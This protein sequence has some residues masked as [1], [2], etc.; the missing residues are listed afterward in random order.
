[1]AATD[2]AGNQATVTGSIEVDTTTEVTAAL[3]AASDT[4][5]AN[6]DGITNIQT[7]TFSGTA[8]ADAAIVVSINNKTYTGTANADGQ[9]S[10]Q[11]TDSLNDGSY[12]YIVTA[13][14]LAGNTANSEGT[15]Q[16]DTSTDVTVRLN[17]SSDSGSS[18]SDTITRENTP[19]FSGVGEANSTVV[20]TINGKHYNTTAAGDG[21]W[22]L[23]VTD[24]LPDGDHTYEVTATDIAGNTNTATGSLTIETVTTLTGGLSASSDTGSSNSDD[25]T[26]D[27]TPAF[28]GTGEPGA[29]VV[30]SI[31]DTTYNSVIDGEGK[32]AIAVGDELADG[33]YVYQIVSTDV[34]GNQSNINGTLTIDTSTTVTASLASE[35]DTGSS[36]N[37]GITNV[38]TPTFNGLAEAGAAIVLEINNK[39]YNGTADA[40][41]QWSIDVGD[42]LSDCSYDYTVTATD[43]A[44]NTAQST[45]QIQVDS[46][47]SVTAL[48]DAASDT[49]SS[50]SDTITKQ[51][52]PFF[53]G[54][55]EAGAAISLTIDGKNYTT[56]TT[57]AGTWSVQ[58]TDALDDGAHNY[59][60]T[61]TDVAGNTDTATGN[62]TIDN[63]TYNTVVAADGSWSIEVDNSLNDGT[64]DY[65]AV[66]TDLAGNQTPMT[67]SIEID[68]QAPALSGVLSAA[69]D[70]GVSDS[71]TITNDSMPTFSGS[72]EANAEIRLTINDQHY[73][74]SVGS[75]GVWSLEL[76]DALNDG[77]YSYTVTATDIAGN[78]ATGNGAITIDT[79]A[80]PL[81]GGLDSAS[82]SGVVGDGLTSDPT[83]TFSGTGENGNEVTLTIGSANYTTTIVNGAWSITTNTLSPDD[84]DYTIVAE[85]TAGNT[86]E[87]SGSITV[88][89]TT[90]VTADLA[91]ASDSGY[92]DDDNI[93]NVSSP[94]IAGT[95]E[96]G[97]GISLE[98]AGNTYTTT[99]LE[100]GTWSLQ[101]PPLVDGSYNYT[102]TAT[103]IPG[104]TATVTNNIIIDT[105]DAPNA[106][107]LDEI[108]DSGVSN[109]D[110]VTNVTTPLFSGVTDANVF[111]RFTIDGLTYQ[112][113]SSST[114]DWQVQL[115]AS[116]ELAEGTY[117]YTIVTEDYAGNVSGEYTDTV[118]IDLSTN[119]TIRLDATS[120][121]GISN[122]DSITKEPTPVLSG[123]GETGS[124]RS[125][126]IV[127][128]PSTYTTTVSD[129]GIWSITATSLDDGSYTANVTI[130][131]LAGNSNTESTTFFI[132]TETLAPTASLDS[133][134]DSGSSDSDG[135][136][137]NILPRFSGT[138]EAGSALTFTINGQSYNTTVGDDG[139]WSIQL[140]TALP[141]GTHEYTVVY[142]DVAGNVSPTTTANI[143]IDTTPFTLDNIELRDTG[144]TALSEWGTN[145]T[146]GF[147]L[148]GQTDPGITVTINISGQAPVTATADATGFFSYTLPELDESNCTINFTVPDD[149]AGNSNSYTKTLIVDNSISLTGEIPDLYDTGLSQ[150]DNITNVNTP[151]F[152]GT[153]DPGAT[154]TITIGGNVV[155]SVTV[156]ET[157]QWEYNH[158]TPLAD[159]TYTYVISA[160]DTYGNSTLT[161]NQN[162][163]DQ[164]VVDTSA[165]II[166]GQLSESTDSGIVGDNITQDTILTFEGMGETSA[167]VTLE[168]AGETF[169]T[170]VLSGQWII[171]TT[172]LPLV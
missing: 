6:D 158:L 27:T 127:G 5:S 48:L 41:G 14:D 59:S 120:D 38:Q 137:N 163:V 37:D 106:G 130:T 50:D 154:V 132:D 146:G 103:D 101:V 64:Y 140:G 61:A 149:T 82:D 96:P 74:T 129:D 95:G 39:T 19:S 86:T 112:T 91:T 105:L 145:T 55:A 46:S 168:I 83:P 88:D 141:E 71:D 110:Q 122:S 4:G 25:I 70:T 65:Q 128:E 159:G 131:D 67:G 156:D 60:V 148:E 66:A 164:L 31:N 93:T 23:Q 57:D 16:I 36:I 7:P 54:T 99:V 20:L 87:R 133:A 15:I 30:L 44:G 119:V 13:T 123:T 108:S 97:A 165:P 170:T 10:I 89:N 32:W 12:D 17:S 161:S 78:T 2:L 135:I 35:S 8:E 79:L 85:D 171:T 84:Y 142:T 1:M 77:D 113:T 139:S 9:W 81:S 21:T 166:T 76:P 11:V 56:T 3:D 22:V 49:G 162:V 143:T 116:S 121:T 107:R 157:G 117:T 34:A 114:G 28:S 167:E 160:V 115:P 152:V 125:V 172:E 151:Q 52:T 153:T 92:D 47:T 26:H 118:T 72:G 98:I 111:V 150:D 40:S 147:T 134:S 69:S 58:V 104:N 75:N 24:A 138:A 94:M 29:T 63:T 53:S 90:F 126:S 80:P 33:P 102:V 109:I 73:F 136:T 45:G 42:A 18:D 144:G 68:T 62:I 169:T 155:G 43:I 124:A 100:D 51:S